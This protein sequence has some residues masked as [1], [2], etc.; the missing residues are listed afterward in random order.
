MIHKNSLYNIGLSLTDK[1]Y[2]HRYD[3]FYPQ[4]LEK[5]RKYS[6]NMLEIGVDSGGSLKLWQKYFPKAKIYGIDHKSSWTDESGAF[7]IL[8]CD[9]SKV[10]ELEKA[11]YKLPK[12]KFIIDDGSHV[13]YHQFITF[14][15]FFT[16]L[17]EDGGVYIIEDIECNYWRSDAEIYGFTIGEYKF[18]D[19]LKTLPDE[20]NSEFSQKKNTYDISSI[21]FAHNCCIIVKQTK[22]ERIISQREYRGKANL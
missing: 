13:P 20:I 9:Q 3:R 22:E 7:E 14:D 10:E 18:I 6:F 5:F 8:K 16:N 21:T 11:I 15:K 2:H 4:F 17:L 1:I 19:F 12:C